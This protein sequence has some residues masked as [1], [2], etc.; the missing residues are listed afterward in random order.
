MTPIPGELTSSGDAT[1]ISDSVGYQSG[2]QQV[3]TDT[4][5]EAISQVKALDDEQSK[6]I[7]SLLDKVRP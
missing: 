5:Q 1:R 3:S 2:R 6:Q 4:A 7:C